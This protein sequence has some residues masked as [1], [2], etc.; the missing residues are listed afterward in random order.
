MWSNVGRIIPMAPK[1]SEIPMNR[2]NGSGKPSTPVWPF[3]TNF[4]CEKIDLFIAEYIN[5]KVMKE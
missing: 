2:I 5:I 3:A 1:I 4:W